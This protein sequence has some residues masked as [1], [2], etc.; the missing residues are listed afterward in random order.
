MAAGAFGSIS[1][2]ISIDS[3]LPSG[4][5]R[6]TGE[7]QYN[8]GSSSIPLAPTNQVLFRVTQGAGVVVNGS[9]LDNGIATNEP[10]TIS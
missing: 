8:D 5:L 1:F 9:S 2:D 10:I 4:L 7:Y 3:G 6:N